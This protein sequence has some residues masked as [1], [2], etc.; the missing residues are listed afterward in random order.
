MVC[1]EYFVKYILKGEKVFLVLNNVFINVISKVSDE[2]DIY[3]I[4]K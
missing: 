1:L 4:L 2:S 3:N